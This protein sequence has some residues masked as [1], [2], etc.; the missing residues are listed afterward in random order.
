M[1]NVNFDVACNVTDCRY[2]H[3]GCNCTLERIQVGCACD[4][5]RCTCCESFAEKF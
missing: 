1:E 3:R 5:K 2:N 4:D